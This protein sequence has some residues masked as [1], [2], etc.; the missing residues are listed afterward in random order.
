MSGWRT[1]RVSPRREANGAFVTSRLS[2]VALAAA[3]LVCVSGL[4]LGPSL[5]RTSA[6]GSTVVGWK[7]PVFQFKV[8]EA[9][10]ENFD[11]RAQA[12]VA[13][14]QTMGRIR[15]PRIGLDLPLLEMA[16]CDDTTNLNKGPAHIGGTALPGTAGNCGIAGH[17]STYSRPFAQ[18]GSLQAGDE[19]IVFG[20]AG[21]RYVY[22]VTQIWVVSPSQVSVLYATP[23]PSLTLVT[24]H[25]YGSSQS[26]L[27]VRA[28]I[29]G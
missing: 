12:A 15:I 21:S 22:R 6:S 10:I 17:R 24:C 19:I 1:N 28:V 11:H 3:A 4:F 23:R 13:P 9:L 2:A 14:G 7:P 26:R 16:D 25:P 5:A 29:S 8:P 18:L 20:P 27:I